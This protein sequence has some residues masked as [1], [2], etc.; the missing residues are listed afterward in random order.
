VLKEKVIPRLKELIA[1]SDGKFK[2][3]K[4]WPDFID[5]EDADSIKIEAD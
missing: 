5:S 2:D 1:N 4:I 3:F